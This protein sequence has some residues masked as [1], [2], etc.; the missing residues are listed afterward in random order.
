MFK[1]NIQQMATPIRLQ[2]RTSTDVNGASDISYVDADP[3][4]DFCN[5]KGKGGTENVQSGSL[6][7]MD[8]AELTMWYRPDI[9]EKDRVMPEGM[10]NP[11]QTTMDG[12]N[13][14]YQIEADKVE[15]DA[16]ILADLQTQIDAHTANKP[17]Y[18]V[19]NIENVE[20]R[21]QFMILKVRR[22]VN[23]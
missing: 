16:E 11:W 19:T 18:E 15:P 10:L 8:T 2:H 21:N 13:A 6:T 3:A 14:A 20:M 5:W 22:T 23:A 7:V 12:L 1:P 4:L 9:T 17:A